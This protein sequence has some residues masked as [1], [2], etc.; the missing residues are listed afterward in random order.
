MLTPGWEESLLLNPKSTNKEKNCY[1]AR[2]Y[3]ERL[4]ACLDFLWDSWVPR[5]GSPV[6]GCRSLAVSLRRASVREKR[7]EGR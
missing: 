2:S 7:K 3:V 1:I 5:A 6:R 4:R